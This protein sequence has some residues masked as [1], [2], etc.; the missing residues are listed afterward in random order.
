MRIAALYDMS[1][2]SALPDTLSFDVTGL[3]PTLFCHGSPRSDE[4]IIQKMARE[5]T[6]A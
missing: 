4:D 5:R 1:F 3:G 2:L 6:G